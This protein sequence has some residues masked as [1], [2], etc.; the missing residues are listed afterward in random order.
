MSS[1]AYLRC[2]SGSVV[3]LGGRVSNKSAAYEVE[4]EEEE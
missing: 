4:E 2:Q 3:I 1:F